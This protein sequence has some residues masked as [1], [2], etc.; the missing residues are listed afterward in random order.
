MSAR[1][2]T[3]KSL[4]TT[5]SPITAGEI[6]AFLEDVADDA[7]VTM[8]TTAPDRPGE[9]VMTTITVTEERAL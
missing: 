6:R 8:R 9:M 3:T 1:I 5:G 7:R 4:T 2:S